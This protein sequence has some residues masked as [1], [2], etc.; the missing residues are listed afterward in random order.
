MAVTLRE[1]LETDMKTA[2][3]AGDAFGRDTLRFLI[4]ALKNAEI[5]K[6]GQLT[7]E[8]AFSVLQ[9]QAKRM[10]ESI[11]QFNAGHRPDLAGK[12]IAQLGILR[13]YLPAEMP[14]EELHALVREIIAE[15][16]ATSAKDMAKVMPVLIERAGKHADGRRLSAAAKAA[17]TGS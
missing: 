10:A 6:R 9:K 11:E 15:T 4:S 13:G 3:K 16:G 17:L 5:E 7:D 1:R 2:M 14:D 8:E 12:E